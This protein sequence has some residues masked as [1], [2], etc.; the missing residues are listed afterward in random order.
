MKC[1][2]CVAYLNELQGLFKRGGLISEII[3][4]GDGSGSE[5]SF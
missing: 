1:G 5:S 3:S 4:G 2:M